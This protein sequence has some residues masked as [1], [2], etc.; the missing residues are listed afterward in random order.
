MWHA[1]LES[2]ATAITAIW[3]ATAAIAIWA[4]D[5]VS[6]SQHEHLPIA[7]AT[8]WLWACLASAYAAM[9]P[10]RSSRAGWTWSVTSLWVVTAAVCVF[11]P[12]MV[13]G[14]DPTRIPLGVLVAPPVAAAVTGLLSMRQA[15]S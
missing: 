9:T 5:L 1:A 10:Q 8:T 12:A 7:L 3:V 14:T 4:P 13:T 15:T 6:G 2:T 11:A